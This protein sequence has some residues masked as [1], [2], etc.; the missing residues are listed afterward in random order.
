MKGKK[1]S[2][3]RQRAQKRETGKP[4]RPS[5]QGPVPKRGPREGQAIA[6]RSAR[7]GVPEEQ[8]QGPP[9]PEIVWPDPREDSPPPEVRLTGGDLDADWQ[10]AADVGEEAVGGSVATPDQDRVDALGRALGVPRAPDEEVRTS[11]E[12]LGGRD[13]NRWNEE[14]DTRGE[15]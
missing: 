10:R 8:L 9:P 13:R 1:S 4:P 7:R 11:G 3:R 14:P 12:I 2:A 5:R 6:E 15:T